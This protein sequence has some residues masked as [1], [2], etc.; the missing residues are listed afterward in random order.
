MSGTALPRL[1]VVDDEPNVLHALRRTLRGHADVQMFTD[2]RQALAQLERD[3]ADEVPPEAVVCDMR[4]P[5]LDGAQTLARAHELSPDSTRVLLTGQTDLG[6]A[7]RAVND[8]QIF[9][10]LTKPCP[11]EHLLR[12]VEDAV[13]QHRLVTSERVLLEQTLK[14]AVTAL[15]E[16]LGLADPQV[17]TRAVRIKRLATRLARALGAPMTWDLEIAVMLA[18]LGLVSVPRSVLDK[19]DRGAPLSEAESQALD[20]APEVSA[21]LVAGVSRLEPV[22]HAIACSRLRHDG[23]GSP[24]G[25]P[26][27]GEIPLASRLLRL[28]T[29]LERATTGGL[30]EDDA[31]MLLRRDE[32]AYDPALLEAAARGSRAT[33]RNLQLVKVPELRRGM[34]VAADITS[35]SG[36]LLIGRG[37]PITAGVVERLRN[38]EENGSLPGRI[39]V[40]LA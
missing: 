16:T 20:R 10:F 8:G 33:A 29:D 30:A 7:V 26:V 24:A 15:L 22:H 18:H 19:L 28:A 6:A 23:Q 14:G 25:A 21:R 2:P 27:G 36:A 37:S 4:M 1:M 3:V 9:R 39:L 11:P 17:F 13:S 34:T 32:G 38:H 35:V 31:L 40:E 12:A 5:E